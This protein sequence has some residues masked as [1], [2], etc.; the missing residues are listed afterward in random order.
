MKEP[1][2]IEKTDNHKDE[3]CRIVGCKS[4]ALKIPF[5][6]PS[7][8]VKAYKNGNLVIFA[9]S[10]VSTESSSVL[11]F[12]FY[13][14][15]KQLLEI[16]DEEKIEFS[17]L[18]TRFSSSPRTRKDLF[19]AIRN[20]I[21]YVKSFPQLYS[22]AT[23]FHRELSTIPHLSDIFTTNWDDFFERECHAT[24]IVTGK[25]FAVIQDTVGRKVFKLHGSIY[26]YGSI[27]ATEE[28][29]KKCYSKL[30][31]GI[32]GAKLKI[33]LMSKTLL[34]FG[35]SFDDKDFQRLYRLLRIEVGGLIPKSYVV[36]LDKQAKKK[37]NSLKINA[38]PIITGAAFFIRQFKKKLVEEKLMLPD[39]KYDGINEAIKKLLEEHHKI[40][41]H[42]LKN[43]PDCIYSI[44]YQDG[45][46]HALQR[47]ISTK[48]SGVYSC[49][50]HVLDLVQRHEDHIEKLLHDGKYDYVAY[51]IGNTNGL[52][53]LL[54]DEKDRELMP[55]YFLFNCDD[56]LHFDQYLE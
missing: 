40:D 12:T 22:S 20:R 42:Y 25:D 36:T 32:I 16:P 15:I 2:L 9:G 38:T 48:K 33:L 51:Y 43:H 30:I 1:A 11:P 55:M 54:L 47:I 28:D 13:Q 6:F 24:P 10:G 44:C 46:R 39:E 27:V 29:Y 31:K 5:D 19:W 52:M 14:Q 35:F 37:L 56:I 23:E 50:P 17:K 45:F 49:V 21:D 3:D 41:V 8:V 4:C 18:M 53:Y 26:N 7:D 34:F